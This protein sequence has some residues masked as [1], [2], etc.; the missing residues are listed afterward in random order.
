M[1][2]DE[3]VDEEM[4]NYIKKLQKEVAEKKKKE[5]QKAQESQIDTLP[6]KR[7]RPVVKRAEDL[8]E[9]DEYTEQKK[10]AEIQTEQD[11]V[12]EKKERKNQNEQIQQDT[13]GFSILRI[14]RELEQLK[15]WCQKLEEHAKFSFRHMQ[16][17]EQ[18]NKDLWL[19]SLNAMST[20]L[21]PPEVSDKATEIYNWWQNL[22]KER[23]W[24]IYK[25]EEK[26]SHAEKVIEALNLGNNS[27]ALRNEEKI[28]P[29]MDNL[30]EKIRKIFYPN[31]GL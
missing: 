2:D 10:E 28:K 9:I 18:E 17:I 26:L 25:A 11:V 14:E 30:Q 29:A 13:Y 22:K 5:E 6:K 24:N 16:S 15:D 31:Y 4:D 21:E 8:P 27:W 3:A 20:S 19:Q 7:G 12:E 1:A 23:D